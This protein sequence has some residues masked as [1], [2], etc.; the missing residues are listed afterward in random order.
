MIRELI[1][2]IGYDN[3]KKE[4]MCNSKTEDAAYIRIPL[5]RN[6]DVSKDILITAAHAE[7]EAKDLELF[8]WIKER[9]YYGEYIESN[10]AINSGKYRFMMNNQANC[11]M[12]NNSTILEKSKIEN[13]S[14]INVLEERING[15]LEILNETDKMIYYKRALNCLEALKNNKDEFIKDSKLKIK[16]FLDVELKEYKDEFEKYMN[17]KI[18]SQEGQGDLTIFTNFN[19]DKP[20]LGINNKYAKT[21]YTTDKEEAI[22]IY[23]LRR[24][25]NLKYKLN[26]DNIIETK[27]GHIK[28]NIEINNFIRITNFEYI[29]YK[30]LDLFIDKNLIIK[31][32][33]KR[34]DK[35]R[36]EVIKNSFMFYKYIEK[37]FY[38]FNI[39]NNRN[40]INRIKMIYERYYK[41]ITNDNIFIFK[42]KVDKFIN[43]LYKLHSKEIEDE[44]K[45]ISLINL[46]VC[47][48]DWLFNNKKREEIEHMKEQIVEKIK[49]IEGQ[50]V[51]ESK[52]EFSFIVG[53]VARYLRGKSKAKDK[54][55]KILND[56]LNTYQ[57]EKILKLLDRDMRRYGH[58]INVGSRLTGLVVA[59]LEYKNKENIEEV[60][61]IEYKI[62]LL[63]SDNVIYTSTKNDNVEDMEE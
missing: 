36:D 51:I 27:T 18:F 24:Y 44:Y 34:D 1:D 55:I 11:I 31:N 62:G 2:L 59:I 50:Y 22:R 56:Y 41:E 54:T 28:L 43:D 17:K 48:K 23:D 8:D 13:K 14:Y 25:L 61:K 42:N 4:L 20:L 60:N 49:K 38:Y 47:L 35:T 10:K 6:I 26:K 53:Q 40:K 52:E 7:V 3:I 46:E 37:L 39:D 33:V 30:R 12:F 15:F 58:D 16:M 57:T 63:K 5:D 29:P 9:S 45:Y 19:K 32:V 21:N